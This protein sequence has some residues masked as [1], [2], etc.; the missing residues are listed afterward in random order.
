MSKR[1][2]VALASFLIPGSACAMSL[3]EALELAT[4]KAVVLQELST[5]TEQAKATFQQSRQAYFPTISA[6]TS[7][8]RADSSVIEDVPVP[9]LTPT[10][11]ITQQDFGPL[12]MTVAGIQIKQPL[13][14]ADAIKLREAAR[15]KV[16]ARRDAEHWGHQA[17]RLEVSR[18]YFKV[19]REKQ[20]LDAA[21]AS[22][23]AMAE[24]A[25]LARASYREGLTSRVDLEQA[26]AE[27]AAAKAQIEHRKARWQHALSEL[28]NLLG[29]P[30]AQQ[31][32][33][34]T[35][36][37]KPS[38]PVRIDD[39]HLRL[40][41]EARRKSVNAARANRHATEAEWLPNV[42]LLARHQW[43][44][45]NEPLRGNADGWLVA[46]TLQ[47]TLFEGFGRSG[48]IEESRAEERQSRIELERMRRRIQQ[49]KSMALSNWE[50]NWAGLHAAR[51]G[52]EAATRSVDLA[53]R[54]YEEGIGSMTDLLAAQARLTRQR[55]SVIDA[56]YNAVLAGMNYQLQNG[57]DPL[58]I[59]QRQSP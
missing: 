25:E 36:L 50:A 41:L 57:Y 58:L 45:T 26:D 9:V 32:T 59:I 34:S 5:E 15:F 28:K 22:H 43:V 47:W 35:P 49:E 46:V 38:P 51:E 40:D 44:E 4:Q 3:T 19:L 16:D 6:D 56:R 30:S 10:P 24:S 8:L 31:P 12:D 48:R 39:P 1:W 21:R 20:H 13:F 52:K 23:R 27:L 33:L 7:L 42:N 14:N 55:A 37:P 54:R 29:M 11:A 18:L 2:Y 17:I 53:S